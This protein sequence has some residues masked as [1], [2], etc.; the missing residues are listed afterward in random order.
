MRQSGGGASGSLRL[1][2]LGLGATSLWLLAL[3]T[4]VALP[5][6]AHALGTPAVLTA[7][8][9]SP[10]A[11]AI[12]VGQTEQFTATG[13]YSDLST[14]NLT[15]SVTW[16]SSNPATAAVS[17]TGL[18]T[19]AATGAVT[20]SATDSALPVP[21]TAVLT[22]TAGDAPPSPAITLSPSTGSKK[23]PITVTGAGF[24]PDKTVTITYMSGRS[25]PKRAST[26]LCTAQVAN[27][28]SFTCSGTIPRRLRAGKVG[29]KSVIASA[30]DGTAVTTIFTLEHRR[31]LG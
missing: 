24:T 26:I 28:G 10:V 2:R 25:N 17:A 18:A 21:G 7:I 15:D 11:D 27:D 5:G 13:T 14:K 6:S 20:I 29:Q 22:V 12:G 30:A 4:T 9:V 8:T 16:S 1:A 19:A 23:T 3:S 31:D